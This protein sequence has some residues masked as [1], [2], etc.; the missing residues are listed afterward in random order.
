MKIT[1]HDYKL[2]PEGR[3][4]ATLS[5]IK[6]LGMQASFNGE[7]KPKIRVDFELDET[8]NGRAVVASKFC[9][10]S[11]DPHAALFQLIVDLKGAQPCSDGGEYETDEL[12]GL[13]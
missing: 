2:P 12:L 3:H 5:R 11:L 8:D 7:E 1:R 9:V 6:D 10:V 13:R 4:W